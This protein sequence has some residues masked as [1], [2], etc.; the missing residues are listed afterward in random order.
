M[1]DKDLGVKVEWGDEKA[2]A[3]L[4]KLIVERKGIGNV[5]A[6]GTYRAALKISKEKGIDVTKYAVQVKGI[7]VGAHG[8][9]SN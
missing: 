2:F 5:L 1:T 4:L 7:G 6:E 9:R 8:I 3:K